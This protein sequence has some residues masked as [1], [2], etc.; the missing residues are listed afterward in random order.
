MKIQTYNFSKTVTSLLLIISMFSCGKDNNNTINI[1]EKGTANVKINLSGVEEIIDKHDLSKSQKAALATTTPQIGRV[2][3]S[4]GTHV[5]YILDPTEPEKYSNKIK[6]TNPNLGAKAAIERNLLKKGVLYVTLV[7]GDNG[8]LIAERQFKFGSE[9]T[10]PILKLDAE[11]TYTFITISVNS[12]LNL[13]EI[14]EKQNLKTVKLVNIRGDLMTHKKSVKLSYGENYLNVV[15]KHRFSEI[16]TQ[17]TL[18]ANTAGSFKNIINATIKPSYES[19]NFDINNE[20]FEYMN[21]KLNGSSLNFPSLVQGQRSVTSFSN[22]LISPTTSTGTINF[23]SIT[24]DDETKTNFQIPNIK[25][26]PGVKYT[27]KLKFQTCTENVGNVEG[28]NWSYPEAIYFGNKGIWKDSKFYKNGQ[29]ISQ[30]IIAPGADYGFV[31]DITRLDNAFNMELN[32]V[33]LAKMEM[34][35]QKDGSSMQN[36]KFKDQSLYEGINK[37]GGLNIDPVYNMIGTKAAP[38][39]RVSISKYG[40]V[41]LFGSKVSGGPLYELELFNNNS[42]NS[43][44]WK[45]ANEGNNIIKVTQLVDG[46]TIL[47]GDGSGKKKIKCN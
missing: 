19:A 16:T 36:I 31:F 44:P 28:L 2:K 4:E 45:K 20:T 33:K 17:L 22:L 24:V 11:K 30:T 46:R 5:E 29:T 26:L 1:I 8:A 21:L 43:F 27:L 47:I 7:Y 18:D 25:I 40:E 3:F 14:I 10:T 23:G 13:P 35:F 37:E 12:D 15:L 34:Q 32:G 41:T 39:I 9:S 38:L 42:L 6:T